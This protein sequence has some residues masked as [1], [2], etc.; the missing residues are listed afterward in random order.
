MFEKLKNGLV[1]IDG[2][3]G[4]DTIQGTSEADT[5]DLSRANVNNIERVIMGGGNDTVI[6]SASSNGPEEYYG[7]END[8][9]L[10]G[11]SS[12][13]GL[14][15]YG[16][17]AY[18]QL[19]GGRDADTLDGGADTDILEGGA[20]FDTYL[21]GDGDTIKDSDGSRV[22]FPEQFSPMATKRTEK[23]ITK[24]MAIMP[25]RRHLDLHLRRRNR[26]HQ[27]LQQGSG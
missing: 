3:E 14:K 1:L 15:L 21:A 6:A 24:A 17:A 19:Y 23:I 11:K 26:N 10:D 20:G 25:F 13:R 8:D 7:G 4:Q 22:F 5:I 16:E 9:T 12:G 27:S 2:G 18:A